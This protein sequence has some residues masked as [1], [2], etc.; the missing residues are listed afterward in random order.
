MRRLAQ[1]WQ[2]WR[3]L[4][5]QLWWGHWLQGPPPTL[6]QRRRPRLL[7]P[8]RSHLMPLFVRVWRI[9]RVCVAFRPTLF[10]LALLHSFPA[11]IHVFPL[12]KSLPTGRHPLCR[13]VRVA[14][15]CCHPGAMA[16]MSGTLLTLCRLANW[17]PAALR[18]CQGVVVWVRLGLAVAVAVMLLLMLLLQGAE[19][20]KGPRGAVVLGG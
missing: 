12:L 8:C 17:V 9:P 7:L 3:L 1:V 13:P 16:T 11:I 2:L 20:S 18:Q 6:R 14:A 15:R 4:L 10:L 19:V 5:L